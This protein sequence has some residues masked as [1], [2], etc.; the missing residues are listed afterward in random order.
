MVARELPASERS[1]IVGEPN[2][3]DERTTCLLALMAGVVEG[4]CRERIS[5]PVECLEALN[6]MRTTSFSVRIWRLVV[7]ESLRGRIRTW[8]AS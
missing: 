6:R 1:R 4:F 7:R 2:A 5:T 8:A 3:P